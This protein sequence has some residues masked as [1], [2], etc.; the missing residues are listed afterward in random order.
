MNHYVYYSYEEWGRGYIGS[1]S[2]KCDP[3]EDVKYFGSFRDKTFS[4]THKIIIQEFETRE[5]ALE[6]EILL[7]AFFSVDKN[8]HFANLAKQI[9]TGFIFFAYGNTY[10]LGRVMPEEERKRRG[11][12]RIGKKLTSE[13]KEKM[14][15]SKIGEK[16]PRYGKPP[17]R[18]TSGM[19]LSSEWKKKIGDGVRGKRRSAEQRENYRQ[20]A[21]KRE[22][23]K[24]GEA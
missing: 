19:E 24:R 5:E 15:E 1:R 8:S 4:P 10:A 14:K 2:C 23:K 22:A 12:V 7:H 3:Q 6:A 16:N 13:T 20:A 18:G 11:E 21:L 17:T 9:S